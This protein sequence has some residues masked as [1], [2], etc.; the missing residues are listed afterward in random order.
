MWTSMIDGRF[1]H[2]GELIFEI[3]LIAAD[4]A[5]ISVPALLDTGFTDWLLLNNEMALDLGWVQ[6]QSQKRMQT[7]GGIINFSIYQGIILFDTEELIIRALGGDEILD[8]LLGV[9]WLQ[10]KRLVAD[11]SHNI[12]TLG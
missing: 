9:K 8:I 2:K 6:T 11:Y 4:E 12:L 3:G 5:L 7:A 10:I 1:N